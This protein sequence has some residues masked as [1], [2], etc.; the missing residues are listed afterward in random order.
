MRVCALTALVWAVLAAGCAATSTRGS[1][2]RIDVV[3]RSEPTTRII[4]GTPRQRAVLREV[5]AGLGPSRILSIKIHKER[6]DGYPPGPGV[7]FDARTTGERY[8]FWQAETAARVFARRSLELHLPRVTSVRDED[9]GYATYAG[10][11][12]AALKKEPLTIAD[13]MIDLGRV[14]DK[15]ERYG[16]RRARLRLFQP[17]RPAFAVEFQADDAADFLV[18][19]LEPTLSWITSEDYQRF[20]GLY[21]KVTDARGETVY[22]AGAG[23]SLSGIGASC[24]HY[25]TGID[26]GPIPPCPALY[27]GP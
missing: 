23:L 4:G 8:A 14:A 21:V 17:D 27:R 5:L 20:D 15:A 2:P 9:G 12:D 22:E 6:H 24:A 1:A 3:R 7:S 10:D 18:N 13:A 25:Q 16:A 26:L 11:F 19:G